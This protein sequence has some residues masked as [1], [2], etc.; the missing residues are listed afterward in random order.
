MLAD[1][2]NGDNGRLGEDVA[3][4]AGFRKLGV[5]RLIDGDQHDENQ[6]RADAEQPQSQGYTDGNS[7]AASDGLR[8][9]LQLRLV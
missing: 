3:D 7:P 9:Q 8:A 4:V 1:R 6:H 5:D 2:D